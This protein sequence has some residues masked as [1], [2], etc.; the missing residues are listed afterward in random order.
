MAMVFQNYSL[1]I[2]RQGL[3]GPRF[4]IVILM[5]KNSQVNEL[6][7]GDFKYDNNFSICCPKILT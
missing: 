1:K 2:T 6:E 4:K 7:G 3:F 5:N